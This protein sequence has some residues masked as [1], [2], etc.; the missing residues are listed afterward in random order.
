MKE[1]KRNGGYED[2]ILYVTP[3]QATS[4]LLSTIR[5]ASQAYLKANLRKKKLKVP[6]GSTSALSTS[7]AC[8]NAVIGAPAHYGQGQRQLVTRAAQM[9]A[10]PL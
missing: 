8:T 9:A 6:G 7:L 2:G 5:L 3:S 1:A 4:T 10:R